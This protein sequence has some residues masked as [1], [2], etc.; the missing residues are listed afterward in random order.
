MPREPFKNRDADGGDFEV[1]WDAGHCWI[2]TLTY[3][4]IAGS[5]ERVGVGAHPEFTADELDRLIGT[6][7]RARREAYG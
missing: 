3:L 5:G 4:D 1:S 7:Q 6:L 2:G